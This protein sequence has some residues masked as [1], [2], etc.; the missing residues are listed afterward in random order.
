[1]KRFL[2]FILATTICLSLCAPVFAYHAE[3]HCC[4]TTTSSKDGK[5]LLREDFGN[6]PKG[7]TGPKGYKYQGY[8]TGR[9]TMHYDSFASILRITA[10]FTKDPIFISCAALS[11]EVLAWLD[12]HEDSS[13]TYFDYSYKKG[14]STFH[15]IIYAADKGHGEYAYITCE[16]FYN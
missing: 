10:I 8:T 7:H 15:H 12:K 1:M 2:S 5:S 16:T 4:Y 6:C 14:S 11:S 3:N 13:L 9:A